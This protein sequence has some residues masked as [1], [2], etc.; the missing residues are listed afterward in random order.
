MNSFSHVKYSKI[1]LK[2]NGDMMIIINIMEHFACAKHLA[3]ITEFAVHNTM[4]RWKCPIWQ[5]NKLILQKAEQLVTG[6]KVK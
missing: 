4:S 5:I 2:G 1:L 3:C 6:Y